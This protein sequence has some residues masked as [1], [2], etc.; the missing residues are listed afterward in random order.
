MIEP[1]GGASDLAL[2]D[3]DVLASD[4]ALVH[5][6]PL[7]M[8]DRDA[9]VAFF[10]ELSPEDVYRRFFSYHLPSVETLTQVLD[11]SNAN[12]FVFG[13]EAHGSLIG[14]AS[15]SWE[16]NAQSAEVAFAIAHDHQHRGL[17]TLLL[18]HLAARARSAGITRFHA[19]VLPAN[20]AMLGVFKRAGYTIV[21]DS[22]RDEIHVRLELDDAADDSIDDRDQRAAASSIARL[23]APETVAVIGA[24]RRAG[25]VGNALVTNIILGGFEGTVYPVNARAS[26]VC[27]IESHKSVADIAAHIDLAIVA[28]PAAAVPGVLQECGEAG[29]GGAV[30]VTAGFAEADEEGAAVEANLLQ[31]ARGHGMRLIGP[32]C[33]GIVNTDPSVRLDA[34]FSP[35]APLR[36]NVSFASQS[37]ALGIAVLDQTAQAGIGVA[38]F[39]SLG[40]KADVSGNDLLQFWESDPETAVGVL[41]LE[42]FGNPRKFARIAR[43]FSRSKPLVVVKSGRSVAGKRAASSHTAAL[44][45]DDALADALFRQAGI[46]RVNTLSEMFNAARFLSSQPIPAGNR[47]A[48]V[49]NSG[50]PG[51]LA[52]DACEAAGL[53]VPEFSP[54]TSEQLS[55]LLPKGAG[56]SNPV[57]LIASAR[58]AQYESALDLVLSDDAV[59]AVIIIYTD[60]MISDAQ[61]ITAAISRAVSR[62]PGKPVVANFLAADVGESIVAHDPAVS[63]PAIPVYEFPEAAA[64]ALGHAAYLG[65]WRSRDP[66]RGHAP[67]DID[68]QR[69]VD[70]V[71]SALGPDSTSTWLEPQDTLDLL[72]AYGI[73]LSPTRSVASPE[74]A[75]QAAVDLGLPVALKVTS[76]TILHKTDVGGVQLDLETPA[77]VHDAYTQMATRL[78]EAM[79]GAIV[80]PMAPQGIELIVGAVSDPTFGPVVMFGSGGTTAEIWKDRAFALA[81]LTDTDAIELIDTPRA[82]ALLHGHRGSTPVDVAALQSLVLHVGTLVDRVPEVVE[83]DLNPVIA[84]PS[85]LH[86]VDA[87]CRVAASEGPRVTPRRRLRSAPVI[88]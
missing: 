78:G 50:G 3:S 1:G 18:E 16:E 49:G 51:I 44:S 17:A 72:G 81:P 60:P 10:Q 77:A 38:S 20:Y 24:S 80:Q 55:I 41:Y 75:A 12:D 37:G 2:W 35:V 7:T 82:S 57:D 46:I 74:E 30:I 19:S 21:T 31:I 6:R 39:V 88:T 11:P 76:S 33:I 54:H 45:S 26:S 15:Y 22:D 52:A 65:T 25:T 71:G 83:L 43:R 64:A 67:T 56:M 40:N 47:V 34:T 69:A 27:A 5:F 85:G 9:F 8:S 61:D 59:D 4:G 84:T 58:A 29:V 42:S 62:H 36:G 14:I 87:R 73:P 28:V 86:I 23:L 63:H 13:V 48:I 32:N 53:V 68:H 79:T 66:G 70:V